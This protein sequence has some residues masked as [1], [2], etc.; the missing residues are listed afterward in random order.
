[1]SARQRSTAS[2][3]LAAVCLALAAAAQAQS[4]PESTMPLQAVF[5]SPEEEANC[6]VPT[7]EQCQ[8]LEYLQTLRGCGA[9][10]NSPDATC[11]ALFLE[12]MQAQETEID[13]VPRSFDPS[14]VDHV[15]RHTADPP[16]PWTYSPDLYSYTSQS[17]ARDMVGTG[18]WAWDFH[19]EWRGNGA[20]VTSC[21]EYVFEK[22]YDVNEFLRVA[23][24]DRVSAGG[25]VDVA[26]GPA[27]A[28]SSIGSRHIANDW[29]RGY[30]LRPFGR[31]IINGSLRPKNTFFTLKNYPSISSE[32]LGIHDAPPLLD[33]LAARSSRAA[34]LLA[35]IA[36]TRVYGDTVHE[37][38]NWHRAMSELL[39]ADPDEPAFDGA[40]ILYGG[41][42]Q[43][44]TDGFSIAALGTTGGPGSLRRHLDKELDELYRMQR[45]VDA[46]Q[47]AWSRADI[48]FQGSGWN[49]QDAGLAEPEPPGPTSGT[50]L[51]MPQG[52]SPLG[53]VVLAPPPPAPPGGVVPFALDV[54][55]EQPETVIRKAILDELLDLLDLADDWGCLDPGPTPCDW[56]P[57]L[58][59]E[60]AVRGMSKRQ[61]E[62]FEFCNELSGGQLT[63]VLNLDVPI[64]DDPDYPQ[65]HCSI[66]TGPSITAADFEQLEHDVANCREQEILYY[67]TKAADEARN[68]I[69][70]IPELV[71]PSTG[72]FRFPG[73]RKSRDE[74]MG[75]DF[76]GLAYGYDF[77]FGLEANHEICNLTAEVGGEIYAK[78]HAFDREV[79]LLDAKAW[80]STE[81]LSYGIHAKVIGKSIFYPTDLIEPVHESV[82]GP[83]PL[84]WYVG[85]SP[86]VDK[87]QSLLKTTFVVVFVPISL[88]V[89]V[90]GSLGV[91]L[92]LDV[93]IQLPNN[94][95]C[96]S[97]RAEGRVEPF[98]G[99]DAF[100]AA[101]LDVFIA[102]AGIRGDINVITVSV[103]FLPYVEITLAPSGP[104]PGPADFELEIGVKLDL[105]LSTLSGR[106]QAYAKAGIC[107]LCVSGE[108]TI[109]EWEGPSWSQNLFHHEY[110]VNL[111]DLAAALFP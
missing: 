90:G 25:M 59:A 77:G 72:G 80:A 55:V 81:T 7:L 14:G 110:T 96:P 33:S 75:N 12:A 71:D 109:I 41:F 100:I 87:H 53:N 16:S 47:Q 74:Q 66:Q 19:E 24:P 45:R 79:I 105:K 104:I 108:R 61:D 84:T 3:P 26:Y 48:R 69:R 88:E 99:I 57:A 2:L 92:G 8:D 65:F 95:Q 101:A 51:F 20:V 6:P 31:T 42:D 82:S 18:D 91:N 46:L 62:A 38:W 27:N 35:K 97:A 73:I 93:T 44:P 50:L 9:E 52:L 63:N 37:S 34:S 23:G 17:A 32:G 15:V 94:E 98:L 107:P 49:V 85:E 60:R 13:I 58:F 11:A 28:R 89:G 40:A 4:G 5:V 21:R 106:V 39:R 36:A 30:D 83:E 111:G 22:F 64:V 29:L 76:I 1:M 103:P 54:F 86:S 78:V 10:Q 67:E 102:E 70:Q 56:S 68:R 43:T